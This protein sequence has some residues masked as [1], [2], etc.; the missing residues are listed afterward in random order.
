VVVSGLPAEGEP[1][2]NELLDA[3]HPRAI[4]I[5][6]SE[7]PSQRRA[8]RGLRDRLAEANI[9]VFYTRD[10]GALKLVIDRAGWSLCAVD[11]LLTGSARE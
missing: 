6:D 11:G 1:L 7:F 9:P 3:I 10:Q 5:A 2:C 4:V 8:T